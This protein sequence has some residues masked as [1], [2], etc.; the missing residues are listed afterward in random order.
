MKNK[1]LYLFSGLIAFLIGLFNIVHWISISANDRSFEEV[2]AAYLNNYPA[3]LANAFL[4][5]VINLGL[6]I[7]SSVVFSHTPW[8]NRFW[9]KAL[10]ILSLL[11]GAWQVFSLM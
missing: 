4:L 6:F 10:M 9:A 5:T 11:L 1:N 7:Y 8:K 3:F 2:K